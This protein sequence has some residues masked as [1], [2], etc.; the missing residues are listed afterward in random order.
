MATLRALGNSWL[1]T[2]TDPQTTRQRRVVIGRRDLMPRSLAL[3]ELR[4]KELEIEQAKRGVRLAPEPTF[5]VFLPEYLDWHRSK[6]PDSHARIRQIVFEHLLPSFRNTQVHR[7][8]EQDV[9]R[10][11]K[12][13][14]TGFPAP[15]TLQKE[16]RTL[17]AMLN[18]AQRWGKIDRHQLGAHVIPA[19]HESKSPTFYDLT[20]LRYLY[21]TATMPHRAVW[22]LMANTGL[23]RSEAQDLQWRHVRSD[24]I[25]VVSTAGARTKSG[26]HRVVPI[27]PGA[28]EA[29]RALEG[30][31]DLFVVPEMTGPSL[32]REFARDAEKVGIGGSL[33]TL[34]HTFISHLVM[35]GVPL[36]T[37]QVLAGHSTIAVTEKYAHLAPSHLKEAVGGL[38]L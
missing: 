25:E 23:R 22:K 5:G 24:S 11:L 6:Y 13:R 14:R 31:S 2:W 9:E 36:R 32:S 37:V 3:E 27:S 8:G 20:Q 35:R 18:A 12:A 26:R 4:K 7:I 21:C 10:Y 19:V 30:N 15:A 33:H 29:L 38:E 1:L 17:V 28:D 34:R 16:V